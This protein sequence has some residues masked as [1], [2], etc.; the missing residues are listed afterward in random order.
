L[1]LAHNGDRDRPEERYYF[2]SNYRSWHGS[3]SR[4]D[5]EIPLIVAH[6]RKSSAEIG[7]VV[8]RALGKQ[9]FQQRISD[10]LMA[11]RYGE[12]AER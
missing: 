12:A 11:L 5:S 3:P 9:A 6:P 2:A 10:V 4:L 7:E 8:E 1:L